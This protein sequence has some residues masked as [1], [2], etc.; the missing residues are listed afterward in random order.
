[1]KMTQKRILIAGPSITEKEIRYVTNAVTTAWFE[2]ADIFQ[3][4]FERAFAQ[5]MTVRHAVSL[6]SCTSAIHLSLAALGIGPGDDVIVPEITWIASAAPISHVGA[7]P[8]FVDVDPVTWCIDPES[9]RLAITQNTKAVIAVDLYGAMPDMDA[10]LAILDPL[11]IPL[12]EDAAEATGSEFGGRPAG[13]FG[14]AGAFSF[15]G[16]KTLTTGE[17]GML[18][19]NDDDLFTRVVSLRD[20]GRVPGDKMFLNREIGF[21]YKMSSLQ[22]ALGLAQLERLHELVGRKREIFSWYQDNLSSTRGITLNYEGNKLKN[23][24]WMITAVLSHEMALLRM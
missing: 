12:I 24:F 16:S 13:S 2:N 17:G 6:P 19:T 20:H 4:H 23:S 7:T 21:K 9:M 18:V 3:E 14:L 8:V 1:M 5:R 11:G 22:A 10:L 15:H